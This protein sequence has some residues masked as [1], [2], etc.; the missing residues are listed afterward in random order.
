MEINFRIPVFEV[1]DDMLVKTEDRVFKITFLFGSTWKTFRICVDGIL[2][3]QE[4]SILSYN[5]SKKDKYLKAI[6][7]VLFSE[8]QL[9]RPNPSKMLTISKLNAIYAKGIL[10]SIKT[11]LLETHTEQS[12]D[13]L[14]QY[15]LVFIKNN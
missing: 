14:V 6:Q 3:N 5:T 8:K 11:N 1:N 9:D 15:Q 7:Y 10:K 4:V 2:S 13:V 12:R